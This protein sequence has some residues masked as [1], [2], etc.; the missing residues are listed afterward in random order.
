MPT[1]LKINHPKLKFIYPW[2]PEQQR[3]LNHLDG[4]LDDKRFHLVAA[5]G[6]GKTV[7]GL[8]VFNRLKQKAL[9]VSPT[10]IVRD[11]WLERLK[12]FQQERSETSNWAGIALDKQYYFTSTTY[13]ALFSLDQQF[14]K[15]T[16]DN[17]EDYHVSLLDWFSAQQ[18]GVLILDE[19]H[20]LKSAWW[21]V[22]IKLVNS[23]AD[24]IVVSLTATPPYDAS[25]LEWSRYL[26]LCG[27]VDEEISIPELVRSHSL[28]P[29]QDYI[30]RVNTDQK[31][32]A[33]LQ[34]HDARL[35]KFQQSLASNYELLYLLQLHYWLDPEQAP[36]A[37][38]VLRYL[39]ECLAL[40]GLLK[41]L[42]KPLPTSL[43]SVL[44]IPEKH[45]LTI[46]T[47]GWEQLLQ[48]FI[49]GDHYP[50]AEPIE[51]FRS[52]FES[53]LRS[54]HYIKHNR[55][56][57]DNTQK[58]LDQFNKTQE[59]IGACLD[60]V[61]VEYNARKDWMRLVVLADFIRDEKYQLALDGLEAP[62]GAYPI[63]H[64]FIHHLPT[65]LIPKTAL[66]TGRLS[67]IH[68][69]VLEVLSEYIEATV[70]IKTKQYSE[71]KDFVVLQ[72]DSN[73]LSAAMT[74][75][76]AQGDLRILVGTRSLLGEGWDAP[77]VN[78]LILATQTGAYVSTNQI[79]G[80]A[81]RINPMDEFKV[82]SI[83]HIIATDP[84]QGL[85][86][87][88]LH[89]LAKRFK[90]FAGLHA[91]A[92]RIESGLDRLRINT[93]EASQLLTDDKSQDNGIQHANQIMQQRLE[94][95]LFNLQARWQN[96]LEKV[97]QHIFQKGLQV[98]LHKVDRWANKQGYIA[99]TRRQ[100]QSKIKLYQW[101]VGVAVL[102]VATVTSFVLMTNH[103]D[104]KEYSV[105]TALA[106]LFL[107]WGLVKSYQRIKR[108]INKKAHNDAQEASNPAAYPLRLAQVVLR[109]LRT[110]K[111]IQTPLNENDDDILIAEIKK[112]Y[113]RFSLNQFTHKE[114]ELFLQ[115]MYQ[116]LEP[117]QQP[118]YLIALN[119][120][121]IADDIYAVPHVFGINSDLAEVFLQS[122]QAIFPKLATVQLLSTRSEQGQTLLLKAKLQHYVD[123]KDSI[124]AMQL[125]ERWE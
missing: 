35:D 30:W 111:M 66:F 99:K 49:K 90:T 104:I 25:S 92:L 77:H 51:E 72:L 100:K 118:R 40:L 81:I 71:H 121:V 44:D 53:M 56:K 12:N 32:I 39:D 65:E 23:S 6:A 93:E 109:A 20:H 69:D 48:S 21:K 13:Q 36:N 85:D 28:C 88:V 15:V 73:R 7:I 116:L 67:I 54:H 87:L 33:A 79:R 58:K 24:L 42:N 101:L 52:T 4:Y 55:I 70:V 2:R 37:S 124:T 120:D 108:H 38:E 94:D 62:T 96:A 122:W 31:N 78:S 61:T 59:R 60:I 114:N 102:L 75:C 14:D 9:V 89:N 95:D 29:H 1:Q 5:P 119:N 8:E 10:A 115:S 17:T 26:Q 3:V 18:I 83:W 11:Q 103:Y 82:A 63:F 105:I 80:R 84:N 91:N 112:G 19:A 68:V 113:Y 57:L 16:S 47:F 106:S 125:I 86:K 34:R 107:A 43:L 27:E 123:D 74:Q 46:T 110:A 76:H 117:I 50:Q 98:D 45:I 41:H 64:Y 22:L 97:E